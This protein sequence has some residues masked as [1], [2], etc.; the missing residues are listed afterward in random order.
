MN[1]VNFEL[2]ASSDRLFVILQIE[3]GFGEVGFEKC[4]WVL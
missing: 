1:K 4:L 2:D 3:H